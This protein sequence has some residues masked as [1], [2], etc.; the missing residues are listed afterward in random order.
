VGNGLIEQ[1]ASG[2]APS[3][4]PLTVEQLHC[5]LEKGII[6][7]GDPIELVD[8]LLV[9]KNRAAAGEGEMTHGAR[10]A[11]VLMRLVRL[12]RALD[13]FGCH[14]RVQ[15][16]V[17]LSALSEPEPDLAI[18]RGSLES[19]AERHPGPEDVLVLVEV[20][21]S[22]LGY[23]RGAKLRVYASA[24]IAVYLI[25]NIPERQIECYEEPVAEQG[26]YRRRTDYRPGETLLLSLVGGRTL[27]M[28]VDDA[29]GFAS[30]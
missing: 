4:V 30:R 13:P 16:P 10:H 15:L 27:P 11:Q 5:M 28:A 17:T 21:D 1:V 7:D 14:L 12:D 2:A 6:R 23:D 25:V 22:S 3:L 26:H 29:F 8:G 24:G 20:A 19:F 9:R 18:V